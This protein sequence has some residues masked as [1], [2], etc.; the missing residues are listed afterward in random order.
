MGVRL[1]VRERVRWVGIE[2][3]SEGECEMGWE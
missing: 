2:D 3:R 1:G